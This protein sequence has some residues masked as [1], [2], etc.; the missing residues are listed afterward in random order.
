M[1]ETIS[2]TNNSTNDP[3]IQ[4]GA[5]WKKRPNKQER[6]MRTKRIFD[7]LAAIGLLLAISLA[8][9]G[10][11]RAQ[12]GTG[13]EVVIIERGQVVEDDLYVG[14]NQFVL[15][16]T[17]NGDLYVVGGTIT[18]EPSGVVEGDL[19][20]AGQSIVVN[21]Q[22]NG[23]AR[24]AGAALR[25]GGQ[26]SEDLIVAGYSL[27]TLEG[28]SVGDNLTFFGS[29][30]ILAGDIA[31]NVRVAANGVELNGATIGGDVNAMVGENPTRSRF[32]VHFYAEYA[33][34]TYRHERPDRA[35]RY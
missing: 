8:V 1:D 2:Q 13:G 26:V 27:E 34:D 14:A 32:P 30:A 20:A 17:I 31:G 4:A 33:A 3:E 18:I 15:R 24:L 16:G 10:P 22:V 9:A 12:E 6:K 11:A 5:W 29:Q 7:I 35:S 23:D 28:S 21:G 25:L 19:G